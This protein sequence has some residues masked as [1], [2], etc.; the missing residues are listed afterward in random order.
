M[1]VPI[2]TPAAP[3]Q[4][5]AAAAPAPAPT[6]IS[7]TQDALEH[8]DVAGFQEAR[9]ATRAGKTPP[10]VAAP[11]AAPAAPA[12]P[13]LSKRQQETNERIRVATEKAVTDAVASRDAEIAQ[14][15]AAATPPTR[16]DVAAPPPPA[17][18]APKTPDWKRYAALPEAPKLNAVDAAGQPL[19]D[20]IEEHAAA[21]ALFIQD[22][23]E[24][25]RAT[26]TQQKTTAEEITAA[27]HQR[28]DTFVGKLNEARAADPDFV[29][30]LTDQVKHDLK[31]F[32][33][34]KPGEA[35][36]AINIV[37]EQVYDSP[38]SPQLLLHFS[39]HPA[40]LARLTTMPASIAAMPAAVRTRA[41]IQWIV[42]EVGKLEA[43]FETDVPAPAAA[44][45]SVSTITAAPP[46]ARQVTRAGSTTNPKEAALAQENVGEFIAIRQAARL[47]KARP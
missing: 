33:A 23:R 32:D 47:A 17:P 36:G 9:A 1:D 16:A 7:A 5:A 27:Q 46:P 2:P 28:V 10:A 40:D 37:G 4:P 45:A 35:S 29:N 26:A 21:M 34:L 6:T 13:V 25:E 14:L 22:T 3:A 8:G 42:K 24:T 31:P 38:V 18:P 11:P 12:A 41:H 30:K 44:A 20:S 39:Q 15:R 19:F 43:R